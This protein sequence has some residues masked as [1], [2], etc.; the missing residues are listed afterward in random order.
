MES[1]GYAHKW[2]SVKNRR[3]RKP[4]VMKLRLLIVILVVATL[5]LGVVLWRVDR[6]V[7]GDRMAQAESQARSQISSL[8]QAIRSEIQSARRQLATVNGD[9]FKKEKTNW[10]SFQPYYAIALMTTQGGSLAITQM[11][12]KADSP[13]AAWTPA[14]L[15]Q[16]IGFMG[17]ELEKRGT[18]LLRSF[19]DPKKNTH[20][21]LIFAGGGHAYILV[22]NGGNFQSLIESQRGSMNSFAIVASDGLTISHA[23]PEYIG[24][25]MGDSTLL[26]EIRA[27]GS[28]QGIGTYQQGKRQVF[29][30][31]EQVPGSSAYTISTVA[32]ADLMKGRLS[33]A[34]QFVFLAIGVSLIGAAAYF[35]YEKRNPRGLE[36]E[37]PS[38]VMSAAPAAE[39]LPPIPSVSMEN[40]ITPPPMAKGQHVASVVTSNSTL[41]APTAPKTPP[42]PTGG[43]GNPSGTIPAPITPPDLQQE[44]AEA[45]RQVAAAMGQEMRAPLASILGFSQMVLSKTQEPEVVQAVESIL[46]EARSSRDVLDKLVT[47]SGER[48]S[49]KSEI[50][51]EG[52]IMQALKTLDLRIQQKG[53]H[54][55]K[56]FQESSPWLMSGG[57]IVKVFENIFENAIESMERMQDKTL[58]VSSWESPQGLHVRIVDSGE[59]IDRENLG[60][61]FD[62]FFTTRSYA[63]HVGLGLPVAA[64][65]LKEHGAQLKIQSQRGKGTQ[66]DI[67]FPPESAAVVKAA[68]APFDVPMDLPRMT[69]PSAE[70]I[71]DAMEDTQIP[72]EKLTDRN[73]DS[74]LEL[75]PEEPPLKFL[76]GMGFEDEAPTA[77]L[78]QVS[79][80]PPVM[81]QPPPKRPPHGSSDQQVVV[82]LEDRKA[83]TSSTSAPPPFIPHEEPVLEPVQI[84]TQDPAPS[85]DA[86][87]EPTV[88]ARPSLVIDRPSMVPP[89]AKNSALGSY[90]VDVK[91]PGKRN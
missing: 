84:Q 5:I 32:V 43:R 83:E 71:S 53:V 44:K 58:T 85:R 1:I 42:P 19:K 75:P 59:G 69:A 87:E 50:K 4:K 73:V 37:L 34:W 24:T 47:F 22:G 16:Y 57:D 80:P 21:A 61:V 70:E 12:A 74:L 89:P 54:V 77:P 8:N 18:V 72:A 27:T 55:E 86:E 25:V 91:R 81:A 29:G 20:V 49:Q 10:N 35:W 65:I 40:V 66:V 36:T 2:V 39:I 67:V 56:D 41:V 79:K 52:P 11:S 90:K 13:A 14:Q 64:G 15:G 88:I 30:M 46:R 78:P 63:N 82:T 26:K 3:R 9:T 76:D 38:A 51:I 23:I 17:K 62:P 7:Y 60:K 6:F 45:Y 28:A 68:D 33:L 48:N 31:Y